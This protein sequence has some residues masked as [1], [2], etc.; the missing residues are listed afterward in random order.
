[1]ENVIR[2]RSRGRMVDFR[3]VFPSEQEK[4]KRFQNYR[5]RIGASV[6]NGT[7][8][9]DKVY[10]EHEPLAALNYASLGGRWVM[11]TN[12][13]E[14]GYYLK[15]KPWEAT[16]GE[17]ISMKFPSSSE[18]MAFINEM[19]VEYPIEQDKMSGKSQDYESVLNE[20]VKPR[21]TVGS[22]LK[23][24][25]IAMGSLFLAGLAVAIRRHIKR[26]KG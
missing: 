3:K 21:K 18:R 5:S 14:Y 6:R 9:E 23:F 2:S 26:K 4:E 12:E 16:Y 17:Y 8:Y 13:D 22:S 7:L 10:G 20:Y 19:D 24:A 1:M 11:E 15:L 25:G